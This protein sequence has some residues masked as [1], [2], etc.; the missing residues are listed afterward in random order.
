MRQLSIQGAFVVEHNVYGDS[1]GLFREWYKK[2]L[3]DSANIK[4]DIAQANNSI[5]EKFVLRGVHYSIGKKGQAKL[6][7]CAGGEI[8]DVIIDLRIGSPTYLKVEKVTLTPESGDALFVPSG[9]G[10]SFLV[11]SD[12]ASV[13]YLTSSEFDPENEKTVSPLDVAL[14]LEWPEEY[15]NEFMLSERDMSAPTLAEAESLGN[16]PQFND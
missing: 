2:S 4:F 3:F 16:L 7:T 15:K 9:V 14:G 8:L 11:L 1:R 6:V 12:S 10:H 13:V 5:S